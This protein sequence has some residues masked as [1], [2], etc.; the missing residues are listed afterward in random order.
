MNE[1]QSKNFFPIVPDDLSSI[2]KPEEL[3]DIVEMTPL[4]LQESMICSGRKPMFVAR[5]AE[6]MAD[7]ISASCMISAALSGKAER[8]LESIISASNS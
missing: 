7:T 2:V 4:T 6:V 8:R 5:S 3:V 1:P